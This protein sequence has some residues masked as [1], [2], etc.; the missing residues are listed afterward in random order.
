MKECILSLVPNLQSEPNQ[1]RMAQ[2]NIAMMPPTLSAVA[3]T[4]SRSSRSRK[5]IEAERN[6]ATNFVNRCYHTA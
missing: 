4:L 3:N 2:P 6:D 5:D 1:S